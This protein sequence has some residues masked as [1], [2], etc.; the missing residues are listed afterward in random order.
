[1]TSADYLFLLFYRLSAILLVLLLYELHS[2]DKLITDH[3][4]QRLSSIRHQRSTTIDAYNFQ[5][6]DLFNVPCLNLYGMRCA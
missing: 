5:V 1:M 4:I 6:G 3:P 2:A